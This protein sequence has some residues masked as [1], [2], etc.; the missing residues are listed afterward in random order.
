M[1]KLKNTRFLNA[2]QKQPVDATPIWLMRQAG[3]YLPEYRRTRAQ[4]GNF[5]TLCQTPELACEVTLQPL[6]RFDLDAAI[7]FSDILTIPDAMGLG[8]YF[9]EGEGPHFERPLRDERA[10]KKLTCPRQEQLAYTYDAIVLVQK[11]LDR[12]VPLIGFCGSPWTLACYMIQGHS[13]KGFPMAMAMLKENPEMLHQLLNCLAESASFH[14]HCQLQAGAN[15]VMIF[16]SWGGLLGD[17]QYEVFSLYYIRQILEKL[18]SHYQ[19]DA[20]IIVFTKGG[21]QWLEQIAESGCQAIQVDWTISM[22]DARRRVG[23]KVALQGNLDPAIMVQTPEAIRDAAQT[24]LL[25]YGQ[26]SGHIFNLG[27]GITKD[28]PPEHV[29]VLVDTVHEFSR[30][31]HLGASACG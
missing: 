28:V 5:M 26:G 14:L 2:I 3:R 4:A 8:L 18:Q 15:A 23:Q 13:V 7:I 12:K 25:S 27:H 24:I 10:I 21:N 29:Q 16:D 11:E 6:E 30:G 1:Q 22:G 20:P 31:L 19:H 9:R 17:G